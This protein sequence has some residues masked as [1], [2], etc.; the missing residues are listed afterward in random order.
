MTTETSRGSR[1][2]ERDAHTHLSSF[3]HGSSRMLENYLTDLEDLI[4]ERMW[5]EALPLALALPHV[6]VALADSALRSSREG[7]VH[8]CE[9]W[10]CPIYPESLTPAPTAEELYALSCERAGFSELDVSAGVPVTA[11]RQLRLRRLA[12]PAPPRRRTAA[13]E[14]SDALDEPAHSVCIYIMHAV[15]RWYDDWASLDLTVQTNLAR[16]AVLR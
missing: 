6:C 3:R 8:W 4:R 11:L 9:Q 7:F 16:L 10:L 15:N 13:A 1:A 2:Y 12:R 14:L 5:G